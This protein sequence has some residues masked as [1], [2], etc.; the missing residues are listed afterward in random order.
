ML[1]RYALLLVGLAVFFCVQSRSVAQA[2]VSSSPAALLESLRLNNGLTG[3]DIRPWHLHGSYKIYNDVGQPDVEGTYE[4]WWLSPTRYKL[5]FVSSRFTQTDYA[6]GATLFRDGNQEWSGGLERFL[7]EQLVDPIPAADLL[8][9]MHLAAANNSRFRCISMVYQL[10]QNLQV[11]GSYFPSVCFELTSPTLRISSAGISRNTIYNNIINFQGRHLAKQVQLFR[12]DKLRAELTLDQ[13]E[14]LNNPPD[15]LLAPPTTAKSL[16]LNSIFYSADSSQAFP[17]VLKKVS[18]AYPQAARNAHIVGTVRIRAS[19]AS[20]GHVESMTIIDGPSALREA[21][22][23][24]VRHWV[25]RPLILMGAPRPFAL[26]IKLTFSMA[27]PV[28][29]PYELRY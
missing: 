20:D 1:R 3:P 9:D 17:M 27:D 24:A 22:E 21:S 23:V 10:P 19:V 5:S 15:S 16:D 12:M 25:Y 29:N 28:H 13:I 2:S 6:D 4:E 18:P 7:R 14:L 26:E 8:K 11:A